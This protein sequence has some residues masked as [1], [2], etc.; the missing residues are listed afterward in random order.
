MPIQSSK[1]K[2]GK[3]GGKAGRDPVTGR[4]LLIS[5][6]GRTEM[7]KDD[8]VYE[9]IEG[10]PNTAA[11]DIIRPLQ[12]MPITP[13]SSGVFYHQVQL[14][15]DCILVTNYRE[16]DTV[17]RNVIL[18]KTS[19]D[20]KGR[21]TTTSETSSAY[22]QTLKTANPDRMWGDVR[23]NSS[24]YVFPTSSIFMLPLERG[25]LVAEVGM[26]FPIAADGT[27]SSVMN[28]YGGGLSAIRAFGGGKYFYDGWQLDPF[29][30]S[31]V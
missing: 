31:L 15:D 29:N 6:D 19:Y 9:I 24:P 16:A 23:S 4:T 2:G 28:E 21:A 7:V 17:V 13:P 30:T 25:T 27:E 1:G 3:K 8:V 22:M 18:G 20:K 12:S 10:S 26:S 11:D 14:G 5:Q